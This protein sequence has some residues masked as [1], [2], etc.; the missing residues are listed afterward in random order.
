MIPA[1]SVV[2]A[3]YNYARYLRAAVESALRQTS[4][5]LEVVVLDDGSTDGTRDRLREV[6]DPRV[7]VFEQPV[8]MGKGAALR[9]GFAGVSA[10]FVVVQDADPDL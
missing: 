5:S 7:R 9:R 4:P 1:V 6:A 2:I 8:N 10:D 3:T